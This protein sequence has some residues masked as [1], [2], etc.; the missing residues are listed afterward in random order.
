VKA[1]LP[2]LEEQFS[3][4]HSFPPDPAVIA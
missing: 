1:L 3:G 2:D 4:A